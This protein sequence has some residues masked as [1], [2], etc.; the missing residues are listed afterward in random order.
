[1]KHDSEIRS[2]SG[3]P[4][5]SFELAPEGPCQPISQRIRAATAAS[6]YAQFLKLIMRIKSPLSKPGQAPAKAWPISSS[7]P[8]GPQHKERTVIS[9]HTI[10]LQ[11]QLLHKDIPLLIKALGIESRLRW[12]KAWKLSLPTEFAELQIRIL[13][14]CL[15]QRWRIGKIDAWSESNARGFQIR[16]PFP[17]LKPLWELGGRGKRPCNN[18]NARF[19]RNAISLK[20]ANN[21]SKPKYWSST[22]TCFSLIC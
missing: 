7:H 6:Q 17:P 3:C 21:P 12:S 2:N 10:T 20:P 15:L 1:M 11:E 13:T 19:I 5:I 14:C 4:K 16:H 9:T 18:Q 22:I 8:L